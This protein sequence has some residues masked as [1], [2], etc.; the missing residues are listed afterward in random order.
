MVAKVGGY[1]T[2]EAK[3]KRREE[4]EK[5]RVAK[6]TPVQIENA[7]RAEE[8][9]AG[10]QGIA[11]G[12]VLE[13]PGG[14]TFVAPGIKQELP[15]V[16]RREG[17]T[18]LPTP[19]QTPQM[20]TPEG[21]TVQDVLQEQGA[22]EE[23]TPEE[24]SLAP[25]TGLAGKIP[26][27]GPSLEAVKTIIGGVFKDTPFAGEGVVTGEKAFPLTEET[28]REAALTKI[29]QDSFDKGVSLSESIGSVIEGIPV[30]GS[31]ANQYASGL[32][33]T[34]SSNAQTV[35]A[36]I[37]KIKE[38]ASTGQEKVRNGLEDPDFG[39][40]RAR[41]MEE[42]VAKLEGRIKLLISTSAQLRANN[43]NVLLIQE[44]ILEAKEK[45]S[46]YRRASTFGLTAQLTGTGRIIPTDEQMF[47]ELQ[48][49]K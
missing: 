34:P 23:V 25:E 48:G 42:D 24:V 40:D 17:I 21:K 27:L 26:L 38:A 2:P 3:K 19:Q 5:E 45:I 7:K 9:A 46:R 10:R 16:A 29:R 30:V 28:V 36:E 39:L 22:F 31:L 35:L 41:S 37:N 18:G 32:T 47:W 1:Q 6:L 11:K 20:Q 14:K 15:E 44:A 49:G 33:Q 13:L 12:G 8:A 4:L 43:D